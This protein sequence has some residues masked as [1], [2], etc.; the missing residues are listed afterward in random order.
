MTFKADIE[1]INKKL[2][3][4]LTDFYR[5][6]GLSI[7][8]RVAWKTPIKTGRAAASWNASVGEPDL[9]TK[10]VDYLNPAGAPMDGKKDLT[11]YQLGEN[12]YISNGVPY[13]QALNHGTSQQAPAGF[14]EATVMETGLALLDIVREVR[15]KN[16][17]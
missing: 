6:T 3:N 10:P 2:D 11:G 5:E 16:G 9:E 13:I 7:R 15:Q 8:N 14:V 17:I 4:V 1:R 12:I